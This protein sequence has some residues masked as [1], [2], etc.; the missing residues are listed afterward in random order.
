MKNEKLKTTVP[1][2]EL[3]MVFESDNRTKQKAERGCPEEERYRWA[4]WRQTHGV[5]YDQQAA[6]ATYIFKEAIKFALICGHECWAT[7]K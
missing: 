7:K 3:V 1:Q 6:S 2:C 4:T 5:L